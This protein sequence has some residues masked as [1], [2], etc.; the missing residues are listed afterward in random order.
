MGDL[1]N[2]LHSEHIHLPGLIRIAVAHYQFE[3]IH[4]FLDDNGRMGRLLITLFLIDQKLLE[5]P[6]LYLSSYFDRYKGLYYDYLTRVRV[7]HDMIQW[8]KFFLTG[9]AETAKAGAE[10]LS[11]VIGLKAA[12]EEHINREF[13]RKSKSALTLLQQ[14]FV[15]PVTD[16][17]NVMG[18]CGLS[19][20]AA[21]DLVAD[22][23]KHDIL[24]EITG[25]SRNRVFV[26]DQ[27]LNCFRS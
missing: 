22:F 2:F 1:E 23:V 4:P 16:V 26:F 25:R 5:R 15:N 17:K 18:I 10:T 21:N 19:K 13:A 8:I 27:Y 9:V 3:T 7:K 12:F 14:L 6:L 24:K 11:K 20:K